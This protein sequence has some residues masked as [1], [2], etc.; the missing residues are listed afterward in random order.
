VCL[1]SPVRS[2]K[3]SAVTHLRRGKIWS[4][5]AIQSGF[6]RNGV[7][8]LYVTSRVTMLVAT[9]AREYA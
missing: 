5:Q 2:N 4:V 3:V 7:Y 6:A 1:I 8:G 9:V